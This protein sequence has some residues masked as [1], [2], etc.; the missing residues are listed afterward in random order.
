MRDLY[1]NPILYYV[2]VP[3]IVGLWPL[4]VWAIY[5]PEAQNNVQEHMS[6]YQEAF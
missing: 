4:L 6:K 1:K 3:V 5:I 2:L